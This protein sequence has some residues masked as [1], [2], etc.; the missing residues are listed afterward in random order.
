MPL[1]PLL[2]RRD[3]WARARVRHAVTV[4]LLAMAIALV[5]P[6]MALGQVAARDLARNTVLATSDIA[7]GPDHTVNEAGPALPLGWVTR[8]AIRAGERLATPA[9]APPRLVRRGESVTLLYDDGALQVSRRGDA[10]RDA[11][12]DE[13]CA[14][15]VAPAA[16]GL[17]HVV[18]AGRVIRQGVVAL[19]RPVPSTR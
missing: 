1:D 3:P 7:P 11:A 4:L 8:R 13:V 15:R 14:V 6:C 19:D 16:P 12:L 9:I 5:L 18:L 10:M 2:P 17:P